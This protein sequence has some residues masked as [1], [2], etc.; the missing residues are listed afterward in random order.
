MEL[1]TFLIITLIFITLSIVAVSVYI[2]L[3]LREF[4]STVQK[5]NGVLSVTE[6]LS[7]KLANTSITFGNIV[8]AVMGAVKT[9]KTIRSIADFGD[10]ENKDAK[11]K[12]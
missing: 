5:V 9:V 2:I 12:R 8:N 7:T 1:Q 10:E 11:S 3:I 4:K 6:T